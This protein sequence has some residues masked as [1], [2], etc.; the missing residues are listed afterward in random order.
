MR[1]KEIKKIKNIA[2]EQAMLRNEIKNKEKKTKFLNFL[3]VFLVFSVIFSFSGVHNVLAYFHDFEDLKEDV[4]Y[5][6]TLDLSLKGYN[7]FS[8]KVTPSQNSRVRIELLKKGVDAQYVVSSGNFSGDTAFCQ[9]LKLKVK[10]DGTVIYNSSL[11]GFISSNLLFDEVLATSSMKFIVRLPND[12]GGEFSNKI[13]NFDFLF[14][15]WQ[16]ELSDPS[17]G[18]SDA[19]VIHNRVESDVW[20]KGVVMNEFLPDPEGSDVDGE[21]IELYNNDDVEHDLDGYYLTDAD[22]NRIDIETCRTLGNTTVIPA[23]G[24]MV[25][26]VKTSETCNSHGFSMNNSGDTL[27]FYD[28]NDNIKDSYTYDGN[29]G[30]EPGATPGGSNDESCDGFVPTNKSYARIPDG[31]GDWIDPMPTPGAPN[32]IDNAADFLEWW[33]NNS[34]SN[35]DPVLEAVSQGD[36][37][38]PEVDEEQDNESNDEEDESDGSEEEDSE[39]SA[40]EEEEGESNGSEEEDSEEST[41]EEGDESEEEDSEEEDSEE[42]TEEEGDESEEEDSEESAEEEA[43]EE[44]GDESEEEANEE[45]ANEE[46][47]EASEEPTEEEANEEEGDE[48]DKSDDSE[49]EDDTDESSDPN[50]DSQNDNEDEEKEDIS[51]D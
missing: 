43:N 13:C 27:N 16:K 25:V 31:L 23:N 34:I 38:V 14:N 8:K 28:D 21:W 18:F 41:E 49:E 15:I 17:L 32:T 2:K 50:Q 42:S 5:A 46:E 36:D 24:W 19:E 4:L 7:K 26:Y 22:D 29:D 44:E 3:S 9:E 10:R 1:K 12:T 11:T 35:Q 47:D 30:C 33:V 37:G 45:E 20:A 48:E 6:G 51:I 39:E 40:E